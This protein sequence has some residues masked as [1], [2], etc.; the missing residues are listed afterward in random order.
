MGNKAAFSRLL[1]QHYNTIYRVSRSILKNECDIEDALQEAAIKA[2]K[3]I[4]KLKDV[5][6]FKSW[7]IRIAINESYNII[8]KNKNHIPLDTLED[9]ASPVEEDNSDMDIRKAIL[10]LEEDLRLVTVLYYYEDL[11]IKSI[12]TIMN[13]PEGTVK[14]RLSRARN[15]LLNDLNI[16]EGV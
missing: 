6:L 10:N 2:Y 1:K 13:I 4:G 15:K 9:N 12:S 11:P 3:G 7:L 5:T 8:R 14:S 16:R